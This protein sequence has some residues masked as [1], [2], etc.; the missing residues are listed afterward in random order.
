MRLLHV[1]L[2]IVLRVE[3]LAA[4]VALVVAFERFVAAE[5]SKVLLNVAEVVQQTS[6]ALSDHLKAVGLED[7]LDF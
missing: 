2:Q 3:G 4:Q 5:R 6:V 1:E 7:W